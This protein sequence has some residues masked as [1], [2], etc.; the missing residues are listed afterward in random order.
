MESRNRP[1][2]SSGWAKP[3]EP[4]VPRDV[5]QNIGTNLM[6]TAHTGEISP[7]AQA[8]AAMVTGYRSGSPA[9]FNQ[10]VA[11]YRVWL[12]DRFAPQ[13]NKAGREFFFNSVEPFYYAL[14]IY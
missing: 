7:P 6:A 9:D 11:G 14:R 2:A 1:T 5:W 4:G 12:A 8:Y 10:A 3:R 13:V